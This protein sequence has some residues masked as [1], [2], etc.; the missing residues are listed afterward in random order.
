MRIVCCPCCVRRV[1]R[2]AEKKP[3]DEELLDAEFDVINTAGDGFI[4]MTEYRVHL[5]KSSK[6]LKLYTNL[7][8]DEL[9]LRMRKAEDL[10]DQEDL[11][12]DSL[13]DRKEFKVLNRQ[14]K[15]LVDIQVAQ[16]EALE[17]S[18]NA[19]EEV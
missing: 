16:K 3:P 1:G 19:G 4:T 5:E 7:T 13:I 17:N 18:R 2:A 14:L 9:E 6:A 15:K 8:D 11:N 10:F 12:K